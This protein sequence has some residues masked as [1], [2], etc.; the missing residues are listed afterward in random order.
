MKNLIKAH[1]GKK[2]Y[3]VALAAILASIQP[4]L[5]QGDLSLIDAQTIWL[6]L[7]AMTGR[8]SVA[9]LQ[10]KTAPEMPGS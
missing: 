3:G 9:K 7:L 8:A 5:A 2:T 1:R 10:K 4:A 6:S